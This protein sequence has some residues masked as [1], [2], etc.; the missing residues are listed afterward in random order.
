MATTK[1]ISLVFYR[2]NHLR[3]D[4]EVDLTAPEYRQFFSEITEE[5]RRCGVVLSLT[6]NPEYTIDIN[7]YADL[8]N[9]VRITAH[10]E[11][12]TNVCLGHVIG[13]SPHLNLA[14]DIRRAVN[15]IAFAP[16]TVPPEDHNRK[17]CHNC[18]CGC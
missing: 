3:P 17:V 1:Q 11:G 14:E 13:K 6:E 2:Q 5:L 7:S 16:E 10:D 12:F 15:R 8:L 18:G 9:A 4:W